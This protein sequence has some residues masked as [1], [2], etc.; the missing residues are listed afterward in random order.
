VKFAPQRTSSEILA[1]AFQML[2]CPE[3]VRLSNCSS[4]QTPRSQGCFEAR[5][6]QEVTR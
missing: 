2:T 6:V 5:Q 4:V 1:L 3:E